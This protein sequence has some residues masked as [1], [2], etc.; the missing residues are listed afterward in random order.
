MR[1]WTVG[2]CPKGR[3]GGPTDGEFWSSGPPA[4]LPHS[5]PLWPVT[6]LS[7]SGL[8]SSCCAWA[9]RP[10]QGSVGEGT[11]LQKHAHS[12]AMSPDTP[13]SPPA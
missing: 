2:M 1:G 12:A 10:G 6:H 7:P 3:S 13:A 8:L 9:G 11:R 4:L 5:L